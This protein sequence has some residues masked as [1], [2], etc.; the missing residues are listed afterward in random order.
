MCH[1]GL[2][3]F[4]FFL[5][6]SDSVILKTNSTRNNGCVDIWVT[7]T[8]SSSD[9]NLPVH[10]YMLLKNGTEVSLSKSGTWIE[11]ISRGETFVY[12][13]VA[14]QQV[15]KVTSKNNVTVTLKG[16][17]AISSK[18]KIAILVH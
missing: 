13:C 4:F 14:Y 17:T 3:V 12:K 8:C 9:F 18:G 16:K 5:D 6:K 2:L 10:N 1:Y 7:F 11:R 15:D